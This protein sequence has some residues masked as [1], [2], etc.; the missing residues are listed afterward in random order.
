MNIVE[1]IRDPEKVRDIAEY[2]KQGSKRNW[3]LF[4]LG[5]YAGRR[6]QD[7]LSMR[8]EDIRGKTHIRIREGKTG[9][10]VILKVNP[11]L[12]KAAKE[13]TEGMRDSDYLFP[14]RKGG[15]HMGREQAYRIIREAGMRFGLGNIG[16]HTMRKTFGYFYYKQSNGDIV[17]LQKLFN[18]SSPAVTE[19][20]I[21]IK[22]E[23]TD[24]RISCMRIF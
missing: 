18:H 12:A 6:I 17:T 24:K 7:N 14:S 13:Y 2:L 9:K 21:G 20:Y 11:E 23:E 16:T 15:G 22:Q 4:M 8:V 1:P 19:L 3:F 10:D 5:I